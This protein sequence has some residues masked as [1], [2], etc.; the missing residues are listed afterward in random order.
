[1]VES[2]ESTDDEEAEEDRSVRLP[3]EEE[4]RPAIRE[5]LSSSDALRSDSLRIV[6]VIR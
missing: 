6:R 3:D 4:A 5:K 1:M 2:R